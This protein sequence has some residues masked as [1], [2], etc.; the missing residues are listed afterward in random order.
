VLAEYIKSDRH[1]KMSS[2]IIVYDIGRVMRDLVCVYI[3]IT[4]H[5]TLCC[6]SLYFSMTNV[7]SWT[8]EVQV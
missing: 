1:G 7:C 4:S 8:V 6:L 3:V 2:R 5:L